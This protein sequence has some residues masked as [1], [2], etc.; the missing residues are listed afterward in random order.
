MSYFIVLVD[1]ALSAF[2]IPKILS[3][4]TFLWVLF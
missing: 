4:F 2:I 3:V 1:L